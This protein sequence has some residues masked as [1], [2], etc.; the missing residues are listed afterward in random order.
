MSQKINSTNQQK[1]IDRKN[2]ISFLYRV[3]LVRVYFYQ[4]TAAMHNSNSP[5][6]LQ[7]GYHPLILLWIIL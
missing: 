5:L 2:W 7:P 3:T 6:Y 4:S 1:P